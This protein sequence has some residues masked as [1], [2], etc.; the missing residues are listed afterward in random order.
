M[1][2]EK[3]K[4]PACNCE[5][6]PAK[7]ATRLLILIGGTLILIYVFGAAAYDSEKR[8]HDE[9]QA[10]KVIDK[11]IDEP[12]PYDFF[13]DFLQLSPEVWDTDAK[14]QEF[15]K[16][17][18]AGMAGGIVFG[19]IDNAGLWFGM[20]SLDPYL[21]DNKL[22]SAGLG[23]T[24]SDFLGAFLGTFISVIVRNEMNVSLDKAPIW[25]DV[26]GVVIGCL[27]GIAIPSGVTTVWASVRGRKK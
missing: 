18:F 16:N 2:D 11:E 27:I 20:D 22:V 25:A 12:V 4:S 5:Q 24:Y 3:K 26:I 23:N 7:N 6:K 13:K 14:Q 15:L 9:I 8:R 19:F 17:V 10:A 1:D 21:P